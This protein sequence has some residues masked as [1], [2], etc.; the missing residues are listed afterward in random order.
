MQCIDQLSAED[1]KGTYVLVRA[2]LDLPLDASGNVADF[3]RVKRACD[4][5]RF[6]SENGA[7][8]IILSHIGRDPGETN[9]PVERALKTYLPVSY[10]PDMLG[11]LA[12]SARAMMQPGDIL[13]M[14]NLRRDPRETKNDDAFA[15]E[16]ARMGDIYV[17]D[18]FSAA[19]RA[20][21]S[22]VGIP[23]YLPHFAGFIVR[24]EV[25]QLD[26]ARN[27]SSPS[28]AIL[29]GAKFETKAPLVDALLKNY[30]HLFLTG[31]LANDVFRARGLP[32]GRSL[33][34]QE[35]PSKEVLE[36]PN[37]ISP[38]DVTVE[39]PEKQ[40]RVKKPG[41]VAEDDKIVDIGPDS[42]SAI[43][44]VLSEAKFILWN[45]P[46][47]LYEDGYTSYTLAIAELVAHAVQ[48]GAQVVIGGG[49]TI[50]A[51]LESNISPKALGFLSTG[52]G[53][54]LE[55]LLKGSL[56]GIAALE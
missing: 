48:N 14:E 5:L 32:V 20:H 53:A 7:R 38:V 25:E 21:A 11:P 41:E 39:N 44:P 30:D 36:N 4:T 13:L 24:D 45:G 12:Q 23:K 17:N 15:Q 26:R 55:Y 40:A 47:G 54:M 49:D 6:L 2:G 46:T 19:H 10:V 29:G 3:F 42:V 37:F 8:T 18:A 56:P 51:I 31:A 35:L 43:A 50:A 9:E 28:F 16:L 1:L 33:I 27:P 52:G 22:I 34:S